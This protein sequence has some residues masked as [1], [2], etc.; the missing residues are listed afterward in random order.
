MKMSNEWIEKNTFPRRRTVAWWCIRNPIKHEYVARTIIYTSS[1]LSS[2]MLLQNLQKTHHP[3]PR[4]LHLPSFSSPP[5]KVEESGIS[6]KLFTSKGKSYF[7]KSLWSLTTPELLT[8]FAGE[9]ANMGRKH[10][11]VFLHCASSASWFTGTL[12]LTFYCC[13]MSRHDAVVLLT[14]EF[15]SFQAA[16]ASRRSPFG[17]ISERKCRPFWLVEA[18]CQK[19]SKIWQYPDS[20]AGNE[21][22]RERIWLERVSTWSRYYMLKVYIEFRWTQNVNSLE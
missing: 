12:L 8:S 2:I 6:D 15:L 5:I 1:S 21:G 17:R 19:I 11:F 16:R 4:C 7:W 13:L 20:W 10:K 22:V 14:F 9:P 18:K 3:V